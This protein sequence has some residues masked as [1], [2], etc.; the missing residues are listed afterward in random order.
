[1]SWVI[2]FFISNLNATNTHGVFLLL[3]K[4]LLQMQMDPN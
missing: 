2:I 4:K 1:M 3:E